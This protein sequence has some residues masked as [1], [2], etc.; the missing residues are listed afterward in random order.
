M[1][2][3]VGAPKT[4]T[5]YLQ[6]VLWGSRRELRQQG[7][8]LPMRRVE[9]HV[10]AAQDVRELYDER[11]YS[12]KA[13]GGLDRF[14]AS[15]DHVHTP[16][17]LFS[18]EIIGSATPKQIERFY[19]ALNGFELHVIITARDLARQI[20]S[21][22]QQRLKRRSRNSYDRYLRLVLD[23]P[24]L[25]YAFWRGQDIAEVAQRWAAPLSADRVHI[26]TVPPA[27][28]PRGLLLERF[29]S[30]IGVDPEQLDTDVA[31]ANPSL[32]APQA[33]LMRRVNDALGERLK[34]RRGQYN[35]LGKNYLAKEVLSPQSGPPLKVPFRYADRVR[36]LSARICDDI[37][38]AGYHI[39]GELADLEPTI[40]GD[41]ADDLDQFELD[42]NDASVA[43]AGVQ[44]MA[45]MLEHRYQDM[46]L[47]SELR[48]QLGQPEGG[49]TWMRKQRRRATEVRHDPTLLL[50]RLRKAGSR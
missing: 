35:L 15:L 47:I 42:A 25:T 17:A 4:G 38:A 14:A 13:R 5:T 22:W 1:Y 41:A 7:L 2:V 37:R 32:S 33:E 50:D 34:D 44:A 43:Q 27:G 40:F 28:G 8:T 39:V 20:P 6:S 9:D 31:D 12:P 10:H 3:H 16:R 23:D 46:R 26:V 45:T 29:C 21:A 18:M 49:E 11:D 24:E 30:V 48:R 19:G 36:E